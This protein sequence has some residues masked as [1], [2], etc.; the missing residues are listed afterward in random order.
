M[1]KIKFLIALLSII[2]LSCSSNT[3]SPQQDISQDY[4]NVIYNNN[5]LVLSDWKAEKDGDYF[6]ISASN[7]QNNSLINDIHLFFHKDGTLI[8]TSMYDLSILNYFYTSFY[9][10]ENTFNFQ[11]ENID[12]ANQRIKLNFNGKIYNHE[13]FHEN[14][15]FK[16]VSGSVFLPYS[17]LNPNIPSFNRNET[18]MKVNGVDWRGKGQTINEEFST[19][20]EIKINGD[21]EYSL[22]IVVP[23]TNIQTGTFNFNQNSDI[24]RLNSVNLFRYYPG[25]GTP[26]EFIC[27]GSLTIT[28]KA[29]GYIKGTFSFTANDPIT[30]ENVT[31][32]NG[33]FKEKY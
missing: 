24:F 23:L 20:I 25:N 13:Y 15:P 22:N 14:A 1:K 26:N 31:V 21:K 17:D 3:D 4:F 9:Y 16:T 10:S 19:G 6:R 27:T 33:V 18:T 8:R 29:G 30:N 11:I 2:L 32:T 5:P 7:I 28:E 12:T